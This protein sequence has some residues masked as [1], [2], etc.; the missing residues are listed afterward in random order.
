LL[1]LISAFARRRVAVPLLRVAFLFVTVGALGA[2][3][4]YEEVSSYR[5]PVVL[6]SL[7]GAAGLLLALQRRNVDRSPSC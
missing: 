3:F 5:L 4:R 2:V 6:A 1:I 7:V